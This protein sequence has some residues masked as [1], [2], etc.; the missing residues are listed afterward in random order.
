[1]K[2]SPYHPE[3]EAVFTLNERGVDN[4]TDAKSKKK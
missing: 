4:P 2:D 1:M 3:H